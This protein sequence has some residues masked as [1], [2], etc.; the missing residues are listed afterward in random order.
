MKGKSAQGA[1]YPKMLNDNIAKRFKFGD[2]N[3][4]YGRTNLKTR[5]TR[6]EKNVS[7]D[8]PFRTIDVKAAIQDRPQVFRKKD[9]LP[10]LSRTSSGKN[11]E[12]E[13][14]IYVVKNVH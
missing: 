5:E 7:E 9:S 12:T 3:P 1:D 14:T 10:Q 6:Q 2:R 4:V 8:T 11:L 13:P